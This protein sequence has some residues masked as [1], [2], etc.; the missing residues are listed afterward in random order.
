LP[1]HARRALVWHC[2]GPLLCLLGFY[3]FCC[4]F[5]KFVGAGEGEGEGEGEG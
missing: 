2:V 3:R 5:T 1:P 4:G